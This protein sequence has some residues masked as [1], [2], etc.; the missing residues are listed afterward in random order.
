MKTMILI[1]NGLEECEA[2]VTY[3][4]LFRAGIDV[5]LVGLDN[6]K[7]FFNSVDVKYGCL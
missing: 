1:A 5:E 3:D 6:P 4:L 2:L 7:A